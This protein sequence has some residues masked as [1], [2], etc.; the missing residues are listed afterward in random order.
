MSGVAPIADIGAAI[1]FGP[2]AP[3]SDVS[4][5]PHQRMTE[6][7]LP[8]WGAISWGLAD[9]E[10]SPPEISASGRGRGRAPDRVAGRDG[11]ELPHAACAHHRCIRTGRRDRHPRA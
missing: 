2:E 3:I 5:L 11:A 9:D 6:L 8:S 10:T 7:A 1:D 4:A